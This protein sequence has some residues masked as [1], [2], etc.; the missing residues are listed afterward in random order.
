[1]KKI[2]L[3]GAAAMLSLSVN[4]QV[5]KVWM[6]NA[7]ET[8]TVTVRG[9]TGYG[10]SV[11]TLDQTA[12]TVEEW[13][14]AAKVATFEVNKFCADNNLGEEI[15][16]EEIN[17]TDTTTV[18]KFQPYVIWTCA[19]TDDA[20]NIMVG[21]GTGAGSAATC[22]NFVLLPV[23]DR[24]AMQLLH[25]DELPSGVKPGRMDI[26]RRMIGDV[27]G[28]G[29][30]MFITPNGANIML[31]AFVGLDDDGKIYYDVENSWPLLSGVAFDSQTCVGSFQTVAEILDAQTEDEVA[32]KTYHR[33]RGQGAPFTWN[34]EAAQFEKN[35]SMKNGAGAAGMDV[36]KIGDVE[37][38]VVPAKAGN[39]NRGCSV[40][41]YNL[42]TNE[43][44][45][46]FD[47]ESAT[48]V[49]ECSIIAQPTADGKSA[50]IYVS[51]KAQAFGLLKFTPGASAI[52]SIAA[53]ANAPVEYYNL[54]GVKVAKAENGLFI[55]KQG[56]KA[57]KVVL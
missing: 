45:G 21:V 47:A 11:F 28:D 15:E 23:S 36:V 54:Q 41:V 57:V 17:G 53:D 29:A 56:N 35:T 10:E 55:K 37:Y 8:Q 12:G 13:K 38:M 34:A 3:L 46:S 40:E 25:V 33:W 43:L 44:A 50:Y 32:A 14:D 9:A 26:P 48:D 52:E 18:K 30:Y 6:V 16:V 7:S 51:A 2:L 27:A 42:A 4:A 20:G 1:M 19:M 39:G 22:Q 31:V 5:E 24:K 49:Y